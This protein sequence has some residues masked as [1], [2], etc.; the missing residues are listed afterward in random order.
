MFEKY[1]CMI[2]LGLCFTACCQMVTPQKETYS[3]AAPID[4]SAYEAENYFDNSDYYENKSKKSS[5]EITVAYGN[6][7]QEN[8]SHFHPFTP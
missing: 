4:V 8:I 3:F 7:N 1:Y 2:V 5:D 6:I